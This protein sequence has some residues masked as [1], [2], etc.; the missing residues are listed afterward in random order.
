MRITAGALAA[1][2]AEATVVRDAQASRYSTRPNFKAV[3]VPHRHTV[4]YHQLRASHSISMIRAAE[5]SSKS[6][7]QIAGAASVRPPVVNSQP[8]QLDAALVRWRL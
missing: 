6:W 1:R 2:R 3:I 7:R 4:L 5:T 8:V